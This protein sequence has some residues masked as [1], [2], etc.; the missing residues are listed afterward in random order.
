VNC[1]VRRKD[2]TAPRRS[3][4]AAGKTSATMCI[5]SSPSPRLCPGTRRCGRAPR[6][7]VRWCQPS[8]HGSLSACC[9][10]APQQIVA[11]TDDNA[12]V[13]AR[14]HVRHVLVWRSTVQRL[15]AH[16][17]R[18]TRCGRGPSWSHRRRAP[19]SDNQATDRGL[20]QRSRIC[21]PRAS[22]SRPWP[23]VM[24]CSCMMEPPALR[25]SASHTPSPTPRRSQCEQMMHC[26][27]TS[28]E[29]CNRKAA[30]RQS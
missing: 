16:E 19:R 17:N 11:V 22:A 8:P 4:A 27:G 2:W 24:G 26:V 23:E 3:W 7:Q 5:C 25:G 6:A 20:S 1:S 13:E 30:W 12:A 29:F 18:Q 9:W 14:K 15:S 21:W 10:H 28:K